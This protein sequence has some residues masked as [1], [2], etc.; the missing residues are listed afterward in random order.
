MSIRERSEDTGDKKAYSV[1]QFC[2]EHDISRAFFYLLKARGSGPRTMKCGRRTLVS[3]QAARDWCEQME[4][5]QA[6]KPQKSA[7]VTDQRLGSVHA[8]QS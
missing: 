3:A 1:K 2:D 5:A 4:C 7:A 6:S 8:I